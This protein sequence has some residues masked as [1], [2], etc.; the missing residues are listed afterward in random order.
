M[1]VMTSGRIERAYDLRD[2]DGQYHGRIIWSGENWVMEQ[3]PE[4]EG[5]ES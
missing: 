3:E 2:A 1:L 4:Q 5:E